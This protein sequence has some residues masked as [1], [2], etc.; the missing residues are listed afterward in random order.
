M[1]NSDFLG[2]CRPWLALAPIIL[3]FLFI[4]KLDHLGS[5]KH[6]LWPE[7]PVLAYFYAL[8]LMLLCK[9]PERYW[10]AALPSIVTYL[11]IGKY[12]IWLG[13]IPRIS[14]LQALPELLGVLP[15]HQSVLVV[16]LLAL[17][18]LL[19]LARLRV[20]NWHGLAL[21]IL[22]PV[23]M[24]AASAFYPQQ[25]WKVA[26]LMSNG[27]TEWSDVKTV[28]RN[29][30]IFTLFLFEIRRKAML[31]SLRKYR[32]NPEY[33]EKM[34][35]RIAILRAIP[36]KR[37]VHLI[38]LESFIDPKLFTR[39]RYDHD[40]LHPNLRSL[41]KGRGGLGATSIFG[42]GSARSYFAILC[43]VPSLK[44][45]HSVEYN[46][47]TGAATG[48]L[49]KLL[50]AA[51][52]RTIHSETFK[53]DFFNAIVAARGL[54]FEESYFPREYAKKRK[55]Y[56]STGEIRAGWFMFDGKAYHQN[57]AF[58]QQIFQR[59][60]R[61]PLLN[62]LVTTYGHAPFTRDARSR[63][64]AIRI[65]APRSAQNKKF[66]DYVNQ[67]YYRSKALA[68]YVRE[69]VKMD[70]DALIIM[71][72]DHAPPLPGGPEFYRQM[73]YLAD[74][75]TTN[76]KHYHAFF[77]VLDRGQP[78]DVPLITHHDVLDFI[79]NRLSDGE[80]CRRGHCIPRSPKKLEEEYMHVLAQATA[81]PD[82]TRGLMVIPAGAPQPGQHA[83]SMQAG[84]NRYR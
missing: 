39:V 16:G 11:A 51:G 37:N 15:W 31:A 3:F 71:V 73:G 54:G 33:L 58:L 14:D 13:S 36:E 65:L 21:M 64:M 22:P 1:K 76:A 4:H 48:C 27:V 47:F 78:V 56:L 74:T 8:F 52:Y 45:H 59:S 81:R 34:E 46:L 77:A 41:L 84:D 66:N 12:F 67:I 25:T 35:K 30:R 44:M 42:G 63:P 40:P 7:L 49:P 18:F 38:I 2:R 68:H 19:I 6:H 17:P 75:E 23:L 28:K 20:C 72:G 83:R 9:R 26:R 55:T 80:W 61:K 60:R 43:G 82:Q 57:L 32:N 53:P 50:Q 24:T 29:G 79:I 62:Y 10:S 70:P 5:L 69:L